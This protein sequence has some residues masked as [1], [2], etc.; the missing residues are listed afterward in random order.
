MEK[1]PHSSDDHAQPLRI[2]GGP[3]HAGF[4]DAYPSALTTE[5]IPIPAR[6]IIRSRSELERYV[7]APALPACQLLFDRNIR[8]TTSSAHAGVEQAFIGIDY[9]TL[10]S[11][12]QKRVMEIGEPTTVDEQGIPKTVLIGVGVDPDDTDDSVAQKLL[13]KT[14]ELQPQ[15]LLWAPGATITEMKRSLDIPEEYVVTIESLVQASR[16][17]YDPTSQ[18]FFISQELFEKSQAGQ[19]RREQHLSPQERAEQA[20]RHIT[21]DLQPQLKQPYRPVREASQVLLE[22]AITAVRTNPEQADDIEQ[23][24]IAGSLKG[25][26]LPPLLGTGGNGGQPDKLRKFL[27]IY[28]Q[29]PVLAEA[30]AS[31]EVAGFHASRSGALLSTLQRGIMPASVIRQSEDI[32][33]VAGERTFSPIEGQ[34]DVSLTDWRSPA[35]IARHAGTGRRLNKVDFEL[36]QA[37]V[38]NTAEAYETEGQADSPVARNAR[39][40]AADL[41]EQL[42]YIDEHPDSE[43]TQLMLANFPVAYGVSIAGMPVSLHGARE[44]ELPH[45]EPEVIANVRSDDEGEFVVTGQIE[46]DRIRIIAVPEDRI[47]QVTA[48]VEERGLDIVVTKLDIITEP[49]EPAGRILYQRAQAQ[50]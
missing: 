16:G 17:Y 5:A 15:E 26:V 9:A 23:I 20:V 11:E 24:A 18:Q 38:L 47:E 31:R 30:I 19:A 37:K 1:S 10:S 2:A 22:E 4:V 13:D 40:I 34:S 27:H 25:K 49:L 33:M 45:A 14:A 21:R 46:P 7:E 36:M 28:Q 32:A 43:E 41:E 35:F 8:T 29:D 42:A 50:K 48:Y 12:N 6:Q 44:A 3:L 39:Q